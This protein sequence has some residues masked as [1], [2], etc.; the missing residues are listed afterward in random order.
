MLF[1]VIL[2]FK[3]IK[4]YTYEIF[5]SLHKMLAHLEM[6][7]IHQFLLQLMTLIFSYP[8]RTLIIDVYM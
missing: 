8:W 3:K 2:K 7:L 1:T 5:F 6:F 4:N